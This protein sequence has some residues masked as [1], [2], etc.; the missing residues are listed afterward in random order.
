[1]LCDVCRNSDE[2]YDNVCLPADEKIKIIEFMSHG[3]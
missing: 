3:S 1:M 2:K